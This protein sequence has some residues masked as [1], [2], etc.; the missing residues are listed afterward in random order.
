MKLILT[1]E[2]SGLGEPGDIVEVTRRV[3]PQLPRPSWATRCAG[4][5]GGEKQVADY[6]V[7]PREVREIRDLGDASRDPEPAAV[8]RRPAPRPGRARTGVCSVPL[9][10][11]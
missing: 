11:G 1:Q 6:L 9:T 5:G 7:V 2:V 4:P 3:R 10:A 8:P